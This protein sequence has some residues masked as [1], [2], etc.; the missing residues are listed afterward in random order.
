MTPL[1][2]SNINYDILTC[3]YCFSQ[4]IYTSSFDPK[5]NFEKLGS[6]DY[7]K[8]ITSVPYVNYIGGI[9]NNLKKKAL[10]YMIGGEGKP[11][12]MTFDFQNLFSVEK[13]DSEFGSSLDS[14]PFFNKVKYFKQKNEFV[15]FSKNFACN[16]FIMIYNNDFNAIGRKF[17]SIENCYNSNSFDVFFDGDHYTIVIDNKNGNILIKE[18]IDIETIKVDIKTDAFQVDELITETKAVE[19]TFIETDILLTEKKLIQSD[20]KTE[21]NLIETDIQTEESLV[22]IDMK[23]QNNIIETNIKTEKNLIETE[24]KTEKNLIETDLKTEKNLIET[25]AKTEKNL[26]ETDT[27]INLGTLA[28]TNLNTLNEYSFY[29]SLIQTIPGTIDVTEIQNSEENV[30]FNVKCKKSTVESSEYYLCTE[31]NNEEG[32]FEVDIDLHGFKECY[33]N[34]TKPMNLYLDSDKKYKP[35]FE[36]CLTC[37]KG[38]NEYINNCILCDYKHIK[39]PESIGT[40]NCVPEC[41]FGY[42]FTNYGQYNINFISFLTKN[43]K[44]LKVCKKGHMVKVNYKI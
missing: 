35:C 29:S 32:Y 31:C 22:G 30:S 14:E 28:E 21:K 8:E 6:F 34:V 15:T 7:S 24:I 27:I 26:I 4:N 25:D 13:I 17:F 43:F 36:T 23:T 16:N 18:I 2:S 19:P 3:F 1:L 38:G 20:I 40:T 39:R 33:N 44:D 10:I 11:L 12:W 41:P 42:Y 9:T 37:E 5:N